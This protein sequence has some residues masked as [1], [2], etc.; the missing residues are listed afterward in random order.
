MA[1]VILEEVLK[2]KKISKRQFAKKLG[3]LYSNVFRIFRKNYDPKL[4][5]IEEWARILNVKVSDLI[6]D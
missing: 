1:K 3:V 6:E 4:S 5:T 2:K